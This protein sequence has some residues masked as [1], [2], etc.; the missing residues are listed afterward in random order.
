[1]ARTFDELLSPHSDDVRRLAQS[2]RRFVRDLLPGVE[3]TI[4]SSGPYAFYGFGPSCKVLICT[5]IVSKAGVKLGIVDGADRDD[6]HGLLEGAGK[7]HR[8]IVIREAADLRQPG[9]RELIDATVASRG[10][11]PSA[12]PTPAKRTTRPKVKAKKVAK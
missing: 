5:I 10:E 7:R 8:H 9:V 2:T 11:R 12:T 1:M 3:E 4:D 6:P